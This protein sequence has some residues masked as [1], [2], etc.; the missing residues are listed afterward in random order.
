MNTSTSHIILLA[1][2]R[3]LR[4]VIRV[5]LANKITYATFDEIARQVFTEEAS[6]HF[7]L[8]GRK[9][10]V[11]RIA[12]VT[13]LARNEVMR[14]R[15]IPALND[16]DLGNSFHRAARIISSWCSESEY[17]TELGE[18]R[19]LKLLGQHSFS[20]LVEQV[21]STLSAREVLGELRQAGII[22]M[23][24]GRRIFLMSKAY[25][26]SRDATQILKLLGTDVGDLAETITH[27][28]NAPLEKNR[29]Q[30]KVS[31]DNLPQDCLDTLQQMVSERGHEVL[32]EFDRWLRRHDRH[33]NPTINGNGRSRAGIGIYYFEEQ[34][35]P[36]ASMAAGR[37]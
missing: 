1:L 17:Q 7:T 2:A 21:D 9:Q 28:L 30:L 15:R 26:P 8:P 25:I 34:A 18:P 16:K 3:I 5:L 22:R 36:S 29:F 31:Y 11:S 27:N 23:D 37:H 32:V 35:E 19:P 4:P 20:S 13:G 24:A 6:Q 12:L 10:S 33:N 14:L